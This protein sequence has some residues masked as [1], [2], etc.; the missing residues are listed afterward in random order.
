MI[1]T[2]AIGVRP[3]GYLPSSDGGAGVLS[4]SLFT[5]S[6]SFFAPTVVA[7]Q[8]LTASLFTDGDT[9]HAATAASS[10]TLVPS[11]YTDG[12][13]FHA[14]TVSSTRALTAG[15]YTDGDTFYTHSISGLEARYAR[16]M[17]DMSLG[18]WL[19]STGSDLYPMLDEET[20]DDADYIYAASAT[21]CDLKLRP[22][23]DPGT[24]AN[25]VIRFRARSTNS[26]DLIVRLKQGTTTIAT[27]TQSNVLSAWTEYNMTLT[28][29]E[30]D[31]I[32]DYTDLRIE[33]EAA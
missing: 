30:C 10:N 2:Y 16:P 14:A 33:L 25:Q 29:G 5:N 21:T 15:L 8:T 7:N 20:A 24:S 17:Q 27:R 22:V 9:F 19:P 26:N 6:T 23:Q 3:I 28:S 1:G 31:A 13:T 11:L 18:S 4:P 12:D 32:T